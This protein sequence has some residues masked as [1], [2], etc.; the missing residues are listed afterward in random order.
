MNT[1][2]TGKTPNILFRCI[3]RGC[4]ALPS[5][6]ARVSSNMSNSSAAKCSS[7]LL[8][9]VPHCVRLLSGA[10]QVVPCGFHDQVVIWS[11]RDFCLRTCSS[12]LGGTS[13]CSRMPSASDPALSPLLHRN[14]DFSLKRGQTSRRSSVNQIPLLERAVLIDSAEWQRRG[15]CY[16]AADEGVKNNR[17]EEGETRWRVTAVTLFIRHTARQCEQSDVEIWR[18]KMNTSIHHIKW[19]TCPRYWITLWSEFPQPLPIWG[20]DHG[21]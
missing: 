21:P 2:N 4:P 15:R 10:G 11:W 7:F 5:C 16:E 3:R 1:T 13:Y 14:R 20:S 17:R 19:K 8:Q 9:I 18:I 6:L 12:L